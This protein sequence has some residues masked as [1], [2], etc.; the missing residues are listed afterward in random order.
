MKA[1]L[2]LQNNVRMFW[3]GL[4]L[5]NQHNPIFYKQPIFLAARL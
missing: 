5:N 1:R 4:V 2:F 3:Y